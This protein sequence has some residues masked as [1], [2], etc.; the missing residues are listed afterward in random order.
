MINHGVFSLEACRDQG[1]PAGL[2]LSVDRVGKEITDRVDFHGEMCSSEVLLRPNR[3]PEA[4]PEGSVNESVTA[5]LDVA[6]INR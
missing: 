6:K 4:P 2:R 1:L 5:V 3:D